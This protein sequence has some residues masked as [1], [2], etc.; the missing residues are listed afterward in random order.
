MSGEMDL[1]K[2]L[3]TLKVL[4]RPG[5][6]TMVSV[7][8]PV[9]LGDGIEM[10]L[11]ES[12]GVTVVATRAEADRRG[13]PIDFEAAWLTIEVHSSL[14]AVGLTRALS[15]ALGDAGISCNVVAGFFHDHLLVPFDRADE[16]VAALEALRATV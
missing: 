8:E 14:E 15:A 12:E 16:A 5:S 1:A 10:V 7:P 3:A 6:F 11:N 4:R 9:P 13:W 2:M